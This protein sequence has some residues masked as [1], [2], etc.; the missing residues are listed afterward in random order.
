MRSSH[1]GNPYPSTIERFAID[2]SPYGLR[3]MA[4]NMSDWCVDVYRESGPSVGPLGRVTPGAVADGVEG[5]LVVRRG[6]S[7][8][9]TASRLVLS[10]RN[11]DKPV[12][13]S[14]FLSFRLARQLS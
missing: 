9:S 7:W 11:G 12:F 8:D 14:F 3:G 4:G 5:E 2:E 1:P 10:K 13:R 6:G